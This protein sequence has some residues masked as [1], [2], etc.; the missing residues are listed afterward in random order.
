M[1]RRSSSDQFQSLGQQSAGDASVTVA[2]FQCF[3]GIAGDMALGA[4]LDAG[5]DLVQD[6]IDANPDWLKLL[7]RLPPEIAPSAA[8]VRDRL[9]PQG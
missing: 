8:T 1:S 5:A 9:A 4:L 2:W 3:S 7:E 6:V